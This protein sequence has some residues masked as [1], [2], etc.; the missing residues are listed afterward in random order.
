MVNL[1]VIIP[2]YHSQNTIAKLVAKIISEIG[3]KINGY[4]IVL[5]NDG[6]TDNSDTICRNLALKHKSKIIYVRLSKNFSEH[7][8][9]MAGLNICNGRYAVIIDDDFQ[10][11]PSEILSLY[12]KIV[13]T[14]KQVVFSRY[15]KKKHSILRNLGSRFNDKIANIMLKK[16]ANLYLSSFKIISRPLINEIIKYKGPYP[17]ID[18]LILRSTTEIETMLVTHSGRNEGKSNYTLRKLVKLWSNMFI[19]FSLLPLRISIVLGVAFS[20]LGFIFAILIVIEKM[21]NPDIPLGWSSIAMSIM[22]FSG[23][24]LI[25]LGLIG[26]FIGRLY[27]SSNGTT[28]YVIAEIIQKDGK[29]VD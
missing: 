24:Q 26:E 9:V 25:I 23:I 1:S 13:E 20:C 21:Q 11:P 6:S 17:Y 8:T 28:Q 2:V 3:R 19:N 16:P 14:G 22:V 15:A 4:E 7:N 12:T 29:K 10:N 27:L 5:V 18:G